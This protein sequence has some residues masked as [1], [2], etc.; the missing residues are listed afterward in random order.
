VPWSVGCILSSRNFKCSLE[1]DKRVFY[2]AAIAIFSK[3]ARATSEEIVLQL[4]K[5]KLYPVL[6]YGLEAC[7]LNK[8][9]NLSIDFTAKR[10]FM[11]LFRTVILDIIT[12][13]RT[14]FGVDSPR[15]RL[16][17]LTSQF[18]TRYKSTDNFCINYS[19]SI[20]ISIAVIHKTFT[21]RNCVT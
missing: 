20:N 13:C 18:V 19:N 12:D 6:L 14:F 5:S 3:V 8:E 7:V 15:E 16:A 10:L 2:R 1:Y 17:K 11:K 21:F 4:V 9:D